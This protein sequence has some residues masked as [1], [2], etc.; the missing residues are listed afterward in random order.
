VLIERLDVG[1]DGCADL[2]ASLLAQLVL[3]VD[4]FDGLLDSLDAVVGLVAGALL[5]SG[6]DEVL[7]DPASSAF[8]AGV[9]QPSVALAAVDGAAQVAVVAPAALP[10]LPLGVKV[11]WTCWKVCSSVSLG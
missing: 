4:I 11:S 5:A 9:D 10:G 6:A 1:P 2:L 3:G 8:C 7:I